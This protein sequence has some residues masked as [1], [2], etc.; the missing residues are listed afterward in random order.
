M[1]KKKQK[2]REI[3]YY[4]FQCDWQLSC[5]QDGSREAVGSFLLLIF[6][7]LFFFLLSSGSSKFSIDLIPHLSSPLLSLVSVATVSN[8]YIIGIFLMP[9]NPI[10][11]KCFVYVSV[12]E[13]QKFLF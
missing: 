5:T 8:T 6:F 7:F 10:C 3:S 4:A 11:E 12:V 1:I 9:K 13:E 2:E